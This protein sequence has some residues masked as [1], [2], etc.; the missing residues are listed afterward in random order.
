VTQEYLKMTT[1]IPDSRFAEFDGYINEIAHRFKLRHIDF[2]D[3]PHDF[4]DRAFA[5]SDHLIDSESS[6][7]WPLV[8]RACF[9]G[10]N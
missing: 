2:N 10:V 3:L 7:L 9:D 4:S 6:A 5:N 1:S 8:A